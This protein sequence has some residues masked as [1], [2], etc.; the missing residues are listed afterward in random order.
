MSTTRTKI[1]SAIRK[2]VWNRYIGIDKD[3]AFCYCCKENLI[4]TFD[5]E[6]GHVESVCNGGS[7]T[8]ENLRPIC[9]HCNSFKGTMHMADYMYRYRRSMLNGGNPAYINIEIEP[10]AEEINAQLD[11]YLNEPEP[12]IM[13]KRTRKLSILDWDDPASI[14]I[15]IEPTAEEINAQ[16]DRYLNEPEPEI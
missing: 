13:P 2:Q 15:K 11:R 6:V 7:D 12:E 5:F 8:V 10:T 1:P 16:L 3:R 14:N 4:D 9:R